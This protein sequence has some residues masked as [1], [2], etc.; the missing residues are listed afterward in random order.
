MQTNAQRESQ[1]RAALAYQKAGGDV[2]G[3]EWSEY[4]T[5]MQKMAMQTDGWP[6]WDA[7]VLA[8]PIRAKKAFRRELISSF[9]ALL[10]TEKD[11]HGWFKVEPLY[12]KNF[13]DGTLKDLK[14]LMGNCGIPIPTHW[15]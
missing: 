15:P 10:T 7:F 9:E 6:T 12:W 13:G 1:I 4:R 5:A 14:R 2:S 3:D 11:D 8:A